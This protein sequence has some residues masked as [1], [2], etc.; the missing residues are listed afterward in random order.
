MLYAMQSDDLPPALKSTDSDNNE[1]GDD[2]RNA[3]DPQDIAV[4]VLPPEESLIPL[5]RSVRRRCSPPH[6]HLCGH[7]IRGSVMSE[8]TYLQQNA[9]VW[10]VKFLKELAVAINRQICKLWS[11]FF[12]FVAWTQQRRCK[13]V[14]PSL[15]IKRLISSFRERTS[16]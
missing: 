13:F 11:R 14:L 3:K 10:Y 15:H 2:I 4:E 16:K 12:S 1:G 5:R 7:E 9:F 6:C 8:M